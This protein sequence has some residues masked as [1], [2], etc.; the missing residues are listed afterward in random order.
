MQPLAT[1]PEA[2]RAAPATMAGATA[3]PLP[4]CVKPA[5]A[6]LVDRAPDGNDWLH[7]VKF[8]GYR[9]LARIGDGAVRLISR[10]ALDWTPRFRAIAGELAQLPVK[11]AVLDG[12]VVAVNPKGV[13]DFGALQEAPSTSGGTTRLVYYA[14]Y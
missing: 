11:T 2:I 5:L 3:A 7:E 4:A 9:I 6:T 10:R 1:G 12:E 13:R 14:F 8:D